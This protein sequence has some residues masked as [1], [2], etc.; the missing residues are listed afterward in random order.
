[1]TIRRRA[2]SA[3][4]STIPEEGIIMSKLKATDDNVDHF[5]DAVKFAEEYLANV[6]RPEE[7][8]RG[9]I[10]VSCKDGAE[11]PDVIVTLQLDICEMTN[12]MH[13]ARGVLVDSPS[14]EDYDMELAG[15]ETAIHMHLRQHGFY[16]EKAEFTRFDKRTRVDMQFD[17]DGQPIHADDHCI[18]AAAAQIQ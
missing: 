1:M 7:D 14:D 9:R 17:D 15:F 5:T 6:A 4:Q 3:I 2:A 11:F 10:P 12:A 8:A 16:Q 18:H 13:V